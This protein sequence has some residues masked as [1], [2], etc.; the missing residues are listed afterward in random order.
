MS[1]YLTGI[2]TFFGNLYS[3]EERWNDW[4]EEGIYDGSRKRL[5][6]F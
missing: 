5:R 3:T 1:L 2:D 4:T 6:S